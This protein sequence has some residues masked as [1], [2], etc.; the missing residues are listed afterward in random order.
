MYPCKPSTYGYLARHKS[1]QICRKM[2][3]LSRQA[4]CVHL[5]YL[6]LLLSTCPEE[7]HT[8]IPKW[9][10]FCAVAGVAEDWLCEFASTDIAAF[11]SGIKRVGCFL[12]L[13]PKMRS[14]ANFYIKRAVPIYYPWD[15]ATYKEFP[16]FAPTRN[17]IVRAYA[18]AK[19]P[20]REPLPTI[21]ICPTHG[22]ST[23]RH[24]VSCISWQ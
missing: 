22:I 4:F 12:H 19:D 20:I 15:T 21:H 9:V 2:A 11:R 8:E 16:E 6:S 13:T 23:C 1:P 24:Q 14:V 3:A 18:Q 7:T 10:K 5:S 17:S